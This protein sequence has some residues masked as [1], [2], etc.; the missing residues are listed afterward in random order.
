M[1]SY[2]ANGVHEILYHANGICLPKFLTE[3]L[4]VGDF[5]QHLDFCQSVVSP[6]FGIPCVG[7]V[8]LFAKTVRILCGDFMNSPNAASPGFAN[9]QV[10][11]RILEAGI[12][13]NSTWE[14]CSFHTGVVLWI[15]T[16]PIGI[17]NSKGT[18][19]VIVVRNSWH[20][21]LLEIQ[22]NQ[23]FWKFPKIHP[24]GMAFLAL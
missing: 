15:L 2:C 14:K 20:R 5:W 12:R 6:A 24:C 19:A 1:W 23:A 13:K 9:A 18:T 22:T 3:V 17:Q 21:E 16:I 8:C 11:C 10:Q 7:G 4:V